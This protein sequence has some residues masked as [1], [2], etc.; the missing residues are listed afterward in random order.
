MDLVIIYM[1]NIKYKFKFLKKE[2]FIVFFFY[3]RIKAF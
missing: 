3:H 2:A 1:Y